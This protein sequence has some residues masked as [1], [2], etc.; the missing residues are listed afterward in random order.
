VSSEAGGALSIVDIRR[1]TVL[2]VVHIGDGTTRPTGVALSPDGRRLY[3]ANGAA[4]RVTVIDPAAARVVSSIPVGNRPWGVALQADGKTLY[5]ADGRS[6]QISII[7]TASGRV[8]ATVSVGE[9][10]YSLVIVPRSGP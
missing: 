2:N 6:N 10:P 5:T 7:D 3:V 4:G 1:D 8:R 9:R